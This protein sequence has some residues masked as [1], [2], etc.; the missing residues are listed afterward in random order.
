MNTS[1]NSISHNGCS[2]CEKGREKYTKCVLGA[3]RGRIYYQYDYR[4]PDG[5]LFSTLRE[6]LDEC[7]T[8]RDKW[9]QAKNRKRLFPSVLDKIQRNKRLT[10]CE[11][12]YQIGHIDPLHAVAV[13]WDFFS[14]EEIVS[15]FNKIFGTEIKQY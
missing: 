3:F 6:T 14:R 15:T 7:R 8:E 1:V 9:V 13:S 2:V 12:A 10:K 4:H 11:M 5:E